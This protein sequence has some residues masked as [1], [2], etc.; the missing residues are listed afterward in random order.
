MYFRAQVDTAGHRRTFLVRNKGQ[1][2]LNAASIHGHLQP[3]SFSLLAGAPDNAAIRRHS[4]SLKVC[5]HV[6]KICVSIRSVHNRLKFR[7]QVNGAAASGYAE[8]GH[9][10][11]AIRID[12]AEGAAKLASG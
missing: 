3:N 11:F 9:V 5:V 7:N 10:D 12:M 6:L 4:G 1:Q 2:I 8:V